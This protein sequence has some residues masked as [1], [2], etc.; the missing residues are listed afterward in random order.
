VVVLAERVLQ[1]REVHDVR[2]AV[3][4]GRDR[5]RIG[6]VTMDGADALELV[7]GEK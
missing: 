7:L 4:R 6:D 1:R 2:H 5:C 3:E